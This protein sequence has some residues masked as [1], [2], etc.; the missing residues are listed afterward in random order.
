MPEPGS[1][2]PRRREGEHA[3]AP[4][5]RGEAVQAARGSHRGASAWTGA[6]GSPT[7]RVDEGVGEPEEAECQEQ[8]G[9]GSSRRSRPA[10]M[11]AEQDQQ[12]AHEER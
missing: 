11:P 12:L 8:R 4:H 3:S 5:S 1:T 7:R 10:V 6:G 9:E 2:W